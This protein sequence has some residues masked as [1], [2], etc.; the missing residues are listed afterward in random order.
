M[1]RLGGFHC[2]GTVQSAVTRSSIPSSSEP[3]LSIAA[4]A[5]LIHLAISVRHLCCAFFHEPSRSHLRLDHQ[6][7]RNTVEQ[8][9]GSLSTSGHFVWAVSLLLQM[10]SDPI[11]NRAKLVAS[12]PKSWLTRRKKI[13]E[14][15][16][17]RKLMS[18]NFECVS[19]NKSRGGLSLN[20]F[21]LSLSNFLGQF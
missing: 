21:Q 14:Y 2:L 20:Y 10:T 7:D 3:L 5:S 6:G 4:L 16:Y 11:W 1:A 17:R 19:L 9:E 15:S 13:K 8:L 12:E 18:L